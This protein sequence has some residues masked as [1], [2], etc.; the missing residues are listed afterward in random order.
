MCKNDRVLTLVENI[1]VPPL[2]V[3]IVENKKTHYNI[4][5]SFHLVQEVNVHFYTFFV[6]TR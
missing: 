5:I 6:V 1:Y 4:K 2:D 3:D